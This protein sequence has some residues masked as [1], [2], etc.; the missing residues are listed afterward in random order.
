MVDG[1]SMEPAL[2]HGDVLF[3]ANFGYEPHYGD[4]VLLET[5]EGRLAVKRVVGLA[6]DKIEVT[7]DGR[8][9]RNG[10]AV[11]EPYADYAVQDNGAWISFP[12][13]VPAGTVF[14]MG[15]HRA[16]SLDSR[17]WGGVP[18]E[19]LR[20]KVLASVRFSGSAEGLPCS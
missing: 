13:V 10:Q 16:V 17:I 19:S 7:P 18:R 1:D 3:F 2:H 20:G 9:T 8:L 5:G 6:G 12:Y 11:A 14:C 4:V 15:D